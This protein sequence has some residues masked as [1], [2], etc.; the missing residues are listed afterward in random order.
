[1][2]RRARTAGCKDEAAWASSAVEISRAGDVGRAGE[3]GRSR[4]ADEPK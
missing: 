2:G 1:M 4:P 3:D